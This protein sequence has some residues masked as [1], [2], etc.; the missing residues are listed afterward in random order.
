MTYDQAIDLVTDSLANWSLILHG[1]TFCEQDVNL[2]I[3]TGKTVSN[4]YEG[5][6]ASNFKGTPV[7]KMFQLYYGSTL[8]REVFLV[9]V[10][11]HLCI[12]PV[13]EDGQVDAF[14]YWMAARMDDSGGPT[15]ESYMK[16]SALTVRPEVED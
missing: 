7:G 10:D 5:E 12:M 3:Q 15:L 16:R 9:S 2:R 11:Q 8:L 6:W 4:P 1:S 13:P 14:H